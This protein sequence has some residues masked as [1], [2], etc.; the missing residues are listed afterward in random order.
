MNSNYYVYGINGPVITVKGGRSLPMMSLVYV[1]DDKLPGEVVSAS[2]DKTI[3]QVYEDS[4]GLKKGQP[5][6]D[7]G[8]PMSILLGPA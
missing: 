6:V 7:T 5:V 3:V 2:G 1:G 4:G 8:G